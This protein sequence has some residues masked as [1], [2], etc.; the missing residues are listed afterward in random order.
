MV[1]FPYET[2]AANT[3]YTVTLPARTVHLKVINRSG[4]EIRLAWA[5][6]RVAAAS[7]PY[8]DVI[9]IPALGTL[10]LQHVLFTAATTL[11][12]STEF[13][14]AEWDLEVHQE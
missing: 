4:G 9:R 11:Y 1:R 12:W 10:D 7:V 3:E 6:G 14:Q 8:P 13:P 2:A 5:T